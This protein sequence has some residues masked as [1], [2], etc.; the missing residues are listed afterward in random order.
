[1]SAIKDVLVKGHTLIAQLEE[2]QHELAA[3]FRTWFDD[4]TG[5]VPALEAE[6][7]ADAGRLADQAKRDAAHL[8]AEAEAEAVTPQAATATAETPAAPAAE[9]TAK[10]KETA[11][12]VPADAETQEKQ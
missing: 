6:A 10:K 5:H 7:K 8:A 4:L 3:E 11:A 9:P 1:M 12:D 2:K